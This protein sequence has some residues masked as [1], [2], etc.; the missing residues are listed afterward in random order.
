MKFL[1]I[2]LCLMS[3]HLMNVY[4]LAVFVYASFCPRAAQPHLFILQ[5]TAVVEALVTDGIEPT[6]FEFGNLPLHHC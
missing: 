6:A 3:L 5:N 1:I 4:F 2:M